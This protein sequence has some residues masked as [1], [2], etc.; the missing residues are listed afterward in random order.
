MQQVE[1][2]YNFN[3][4]IMTLFPSFNMFTKDKSVLVF[5]SLLDQAMRKKTLDCEHFQVDNLLSFSTP[6]A[7]ILYSPDYVFVLDNSIH[8]LYLCLLVP[9]YKKLIKHSSYLTTLCLIDKSWCK[10]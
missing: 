2:I 3:L 7:G 4:V 10:V 5:L 8:R 9:P 6:T 1:V